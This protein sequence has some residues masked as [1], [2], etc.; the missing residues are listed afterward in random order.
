MERAL[1]T[2]RDVHTDTHRH[3][4]IHAQAHTHPITQIHTQAHTVIQIHA[5]A[6]A[7]AHTHTHTHTHTPLAIYYLGQAPGDLAAGPDI[8][9]LLEFINNYKSLI[10]FYF[11]QK[12]KQ[13]NIGTRL[14]IDFLYFRPPLFNSLLGHRGGKKIKMVIKSFILSPSSS[15]WHIVW[16]N[17]S[18]F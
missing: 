13:F 14:T 2:C 5:Q 16:K 8:H 6:Q 15:N 12:G 1:H 10:L 4:Q 9:I 3:T 7:R 18:M 17:E 11:S